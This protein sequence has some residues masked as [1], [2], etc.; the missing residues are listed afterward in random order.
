[1]KELSCYKL[2]RKKRENHTDY[3]VTI[4]N[5]AVKYRKT[6][7]SGVCHPL[8]STRDWDVTSHLTKLKG[9]KKRDQHYLS[10]KVISHNELYG[11]VTQSHEHLMSRAKNSWSSREM[12]SI[13]MLRAD[14]CQMVGNPS[15]KYTWVILAKT[16]RPSVSLPILLK[17]TD[18][19]NRNIPQYPQ[20]FQ[21]TPQIQ[22]FLG[23]CPLL[24]DMKHPLF[25]S[26]I[27]GPPFLRSL[28]S[29]QPSDLRRG[30]GH[31]L[32]EGPLGSTVSG[33][34]HFLIWVIVVEPLGR[35]RGLLLHLLL[36]SPLLLAK[37]LLSL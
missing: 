26:G 2:L 36:F 30:R 37:E 18:T 12:Q 20:R 11:A 14:D 19:N 13:W 9:E 32:P 6:P 34:L 24:H 17:G 7:I 15:R 10:V 16:L 28:Q 35:R 23:R 1:M 5:C 27:E 29:V 25:C 21:K 31:V 3:K 4:N 33:V 22:V 8:P